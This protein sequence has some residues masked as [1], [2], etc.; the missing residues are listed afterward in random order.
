MICL[1]EFVIKHLKMYS[2]VEHGDILMSYQNT[3]FQN[4]KSPLFNFFCYTYSKFVNIV[5]F[6]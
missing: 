1:N 6:T 4:R 3:Y 2:P 5:H